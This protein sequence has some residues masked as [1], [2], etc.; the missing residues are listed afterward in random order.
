MVPD[1]LIK[2]NEEDDHW[3][4]MDDL[5]AEI[6]ETWVEILEKLLEARFLTIGLKKKK[7]ITY[8]AAWQ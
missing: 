1:L 6:I 5:A 4:Q 3:D 8:L 7:N 2:P